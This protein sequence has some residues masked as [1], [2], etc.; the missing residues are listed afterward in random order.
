MIDKFWEALKAIPVNKTGEVVRLLECGTRNSSPARASFVKAL[1]GDLLYT[2]L[3]FQAGP[4][5]DLVMDL[6]DLSAL[7]TGHYDA[8]LICSTLEHVRRPWKVAEQLARITSRQ[9]GILY[10]Q[11]HQ[12]FPLHGYP[13]DYFRFST[14]A[15]GEIF[16]R[17]SGWKILESGYEYPCTVTPTGNYFPHARN[18]NFEAESHLNSWCLCSR[19]KG[20]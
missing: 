6:H 5:V 11:T 19:Q 12:S 3:D 20:E 2:G 9:G 8:I 14:G 17:E 16:S 10:C 1:R 13:D 15:L 18:W 4:G 7:P